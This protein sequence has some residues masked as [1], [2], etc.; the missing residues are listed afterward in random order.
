MIFEI[1]CSA[2][3]ACDQ[4]KQR[5]FHGGVQLSSP[6]WWARLGNKSSARK[7]ACIS[8]GRLLRTCWEEFFRQNHRFQKGVL[9]NCSDVLWT[10]P[11]NKKWWSTDTPLR[12]NVLIDPHHFQW[13]APF[14]DRLVP[15]FLRW[16]SQSK[17]HGVTFQVHSLETSCQKNSDQKKSEPTPTDHDR[18]RQT[19]TGPSAR[20]AAD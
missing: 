13:A 18:P 15:C 8:S 11:W 7:A 19:M 14:L 5:S 3:L 6:P 4:K 20:P 16:P 9:T 17:P 2:D 12:S 1:S 10:T